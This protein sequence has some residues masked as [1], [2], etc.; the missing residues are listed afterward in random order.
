MLSVRSARF[1]GGV[2]DTQLD[3]DRYWDEM[4]RYY[5][6]IVGKFGSPVQAA[7]KKLS[8]MGIETICSTHGP[9][10][11]QPDTISRVVALYDRLSRYEAE[12]GLV[13]AYGSMY[14]NTEQ[15]AEVIAAAAAGNGVRNIV[16]HN[17]SKSHESEVLRDIFTYR[18]LIIGS[19]TYNNKLYPPVEGLLSAIQNRNVRTASSAISLI[20]HGPTEPNELKAFAESM[21]L[22]RWVNRLR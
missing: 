10:W 22:K 21:E 11:T 2:T 1:D 13:I 7:L 19:P 3:P 6:N 15:L 16:M 18:G 17:L 12:R 5:S 20:I 9:V 14:G 4:I 8:G